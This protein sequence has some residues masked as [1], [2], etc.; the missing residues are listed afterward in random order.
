MNNNLKSFT[1]HDL[2][3]IIK[4]YYR[5]LREH[6]N[7]HN[8]IQKL[9]SKTASKMPKMKSRVIA[10]FQESLKNNFKKYFIAKLLNLCDHAAMKLMPELISAAMNSSR[11][12]AYTFISPLIKFNAK[13]NAKEVAK[14][15]LELSSGENVENYS[16]VVPWL[17]FLI[18]NELDENTI[19]KINGCYL[20]L[21]L[22]TN[23]IRTK[24]SVYFKLLNSKESDFEEFLV[25]LFR[26]S[27]NKIKNFSDELLERKQR[28]H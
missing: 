1:I 25:P 4:E 8:N 21:F 11:E 7:P 26:K 28:K 16:K 18:F 12:D 20:K 15:F 27:Y 9:L 19:K 6:K 5:L 10:W 14:V 13:I 24:T 2:D 23:D 3:N 22:A 17:H